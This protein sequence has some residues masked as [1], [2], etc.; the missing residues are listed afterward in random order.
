MCGPQVKPN[1]AG[2]ASSAGQD[3]SLRSHISGVSAGIV[4]NPRPSAIAVNIPDTEL[5]RR[6]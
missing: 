6:Q 3:R 1:H 4:A 2:S 5:A